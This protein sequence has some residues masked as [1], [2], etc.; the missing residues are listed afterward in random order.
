MTNVLVEREVLNSDSKTTPGHVELLVNR[1]HLLSFD[2]NLLDGERFEKS[3][4]RG[5]AR[6]QAASPS[7]VA[8]GCARDPDTTGKDTPVPVWFC[9]RKYQHF[10]RGVD[11]RV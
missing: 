5:T 7:S 11:V 8:G 3:L 1:F 10:P 2:V 4:P 9:F 6:C